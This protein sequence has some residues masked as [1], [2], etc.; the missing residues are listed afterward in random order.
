MTSQRKQS[1][2]KLQFILRSGYFALRRGYVDRHANNVL[3]EY[4]S[5]W[6]SFRKI[7][8]SA[9]TLD[10]W[11][12]IEGFDARYDW[13]NV[14][15]QLSRQHYNSSNFYRVTLKRALDTHFRGIRSVTEYGCGIGRNLLFL[16]RDYPQLRCYGYELVPEAVEIAR[17]A[18]KKFDVEVEYSQLDYLR[19]PAAKFIFPSTDVA[20]T[21]FSLE[22]LPIGCDIALRNMLAR[23]NLGTIHL[24]PVTENYPYTPRGMIG[25]LDHLKASYL[26]G[27]PEA[28]ESQLPAHVW[29]ER[30]YSSHNAL[31][32]PSVYVL[33]K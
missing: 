12:T 18:A 6:E 4:A 5:S 16:K 29:H 9:D 11:L 27:F 10:Q 30:M 2:S 17:R 26:R 32:F 33:R 28:V 3:K 20:F 25:R 15:G 24:E 14:D 8:A 21:V 31:M 19:D 22:Q 23:A 7:L 1:A 13:F